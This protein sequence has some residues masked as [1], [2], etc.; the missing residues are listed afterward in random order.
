V[1]LSEGVEWGLHCCVLLAP[2]PDGAGLPAKALAEF[3]G[4]SESYLVKHL[5]ALVRAN[6]LTSISGPKG[7]FRLARPASQITLL[8]VVQG[9]EGGQPAFRCTEIRRRGPAALGPGAY[10]L[11]CMITASMLEAERAWAAVLR[12]KTLA[13]LVEELTAK[14]D[15]RAI[16]KTLA[17][18][19]A[20]VRI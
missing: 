1:R 9:I 12:N 11:P 15:P 6:V 4:V 13:Q 7:G 16:E 3:H 20:V 5:K 14:L 19:P 8:D 10:R 18:L 2:L 17:W